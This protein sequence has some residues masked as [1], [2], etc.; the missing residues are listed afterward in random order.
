MSSAPN[1]FAHCMFTF[2]LFDRGKENKGKLW[3]WLSQ[4]FAALEQVLLLVLLPLHG[5][6]LRILHRDYIEEMNINGRLFP[7]K[8]LLCLPRLHVYS[9]LCSL[10]EMI[11]AFVCCLNLLFFGKHESIFGGKRKREWKVPKVAC[12]RN[13]LESITDG[14]KAVPG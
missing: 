6:F 7:H 5:I 9:T 8:V 14:L 13:K 11:L 4:T 2:F 3:K 10:K 1:N 12:T